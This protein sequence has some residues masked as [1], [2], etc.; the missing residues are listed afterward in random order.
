MDETEKEANKTWIEGFC[1]SNLTKFA[2]IQNFDDS[3]AKRVASKLSPEAISQVKNSKD[4]YDLLKK[5]T[6]DTIFEEHAQLPPETREKIR[7]IGMQLSTYDF[8]HFAG[9][10]PITQVEFRVVEEIPLLVVHVDE[11]AF[12]TIN[13]TITKESRPQTNPDGTIV[14]RDGREVTESVRINTGEYQIWRASDAY[15]SI[16]LN[17]KGIDI[18]VVNEHNENVPLTFLR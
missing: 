17:G 15:R 14:I 10:E 16:R 7:D 2:R 11:H 8:R 3:F 18:V 5:T 4:A 13:K 1:Q 6:I 9:C 12:Q